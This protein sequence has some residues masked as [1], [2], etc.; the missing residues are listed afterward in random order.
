MNVL[1]MIT[2]DKKS[3]NQVYNVAVGESLTILG[4]ANFLKKE[5]AKYDSDIAKIKFN[6]GPERYGDIEHSIASIEKSKKLLGYAPTC[7]IEKGLLKTIDWFWKK[8]SKL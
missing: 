6:Y 3:I 1:S 2:K 7:K 8:Y 4:L 5:I